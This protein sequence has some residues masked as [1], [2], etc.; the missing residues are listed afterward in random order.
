[1]MQNLDAGQRLQGLWKSPTSAQSGE[2]LEQRL[3]D[4]YRAVDY[5]FEQLPE[6][7]GLG[8]ES[9]VFVLDP[10]RPA[11]YS[12]ETWARAQKSYFGIMPRY[13]AAQA[14][15]RGY[16]VIDLQPVFMRRHQLGASIEVAPTDSHWSALGH[17]VVAE[18][19]AKSAVF[20]R[21]FSKLAP[22]P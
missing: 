7:S 3:A 12:P 20:R 11:I 15:A 6:K 8:G 21:T 19:L 2:A 22:R 18:E 17:Q 13:F 16:E 1:M 10:W 9:I 14:A 4:S 5:F